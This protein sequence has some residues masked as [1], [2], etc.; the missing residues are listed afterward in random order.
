VAEYETQ[1][2][3]RILLQQKL[4]ELF[5]NGNNAVDDITSNEVFG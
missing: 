3:H 5:E 2:P 1:L 4:P